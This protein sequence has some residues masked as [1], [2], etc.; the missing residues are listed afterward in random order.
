M[1]AQFCEYIKNKLIA[2]MYFY[3]YIKNILADWFG[4]AGF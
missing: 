2:H 4:C 1:F 3:I